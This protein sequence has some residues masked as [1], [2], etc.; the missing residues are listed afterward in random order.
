MFVV[1][2]TSRRRLFLASVLK[3]LSVKS[4]WED[5]FI[6][7]SSSLIRK[8]TVGLGDESLPRKQTFV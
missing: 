5:D 8:V 4:E 6:K 1:T 2:R 7:Y 3:S